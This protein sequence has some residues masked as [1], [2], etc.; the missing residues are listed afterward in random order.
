[1]VDVLEALHRSPDNGTV[2]PDA[3]LAQTTVESLVPVERG[4]QGL[5]KRGPTGLQLV[6]A[7]ESF[8][9]AYTQ[10]RLVG[11]TTLAV[12]S[13]VDGE[14]KT[15]V[16]IG[17]ATTLAEDFPDLRVALVETDAERPVLAET[18]GVDPSP[19][20]VDHLAGGLALE[21]TYRTTDLP[22]LHVVPCGGAPERIG[23]PFRSPRM[24]QALRDLRR[25]HDVVILDVV[26]LLVNSDGVAL[27]GLAEATLLVVRAGVTPIDA[28]NEATRLIDPDR[29]RGVV[30]NGVEP[31]GPRWLRRL[32]GRPCS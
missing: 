21:A 4:N 20:L 18:F 10:A 12:S 8:R 1:M 9:R 7:R 19:G 5:T 22:N 30:L 13:A 2:R 14:G 27:V 25:T 31:A 29:L 23:R 16:S 24:V 15:S 32:F 11:V 3:S 17:L 6:N 26:S 28:V